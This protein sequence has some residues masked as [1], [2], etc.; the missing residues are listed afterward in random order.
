MKST[1]TITVEHPDTRDVE[2]FVDTMA[3]S[4]KSEYEILIGGAQ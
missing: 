1:I 4:F 3:R 2:S